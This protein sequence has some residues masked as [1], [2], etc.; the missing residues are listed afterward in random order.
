MVRYFLIGVVAATVTLYVWQT[1]S[2]GVLPWHSAPMTEMSPAS[3]LAVRDAVP[4]NGFYFARQGILAVVNLT[5]D[6]RD[7]SKEMGLPLA[8]EVVIDLIAALLLAG[9]VTRLPRRG[10]LAAGV[11]LALAAAAFT[12]F[13]AVSDWN[14]YA[15]PLNFELSN[16]ADVTIQGFLA[17]LVLGWALRRFAPAPRA[18]EGILAVAG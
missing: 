10:P 6:M 12:T 8:R 3:T 13:L 16:V 4:G 17:G 14:W 1:I 11:T 18:D 15:F 2:N 9:A 7:R 5:P